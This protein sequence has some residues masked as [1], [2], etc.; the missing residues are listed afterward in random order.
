MPLAT[1]NFKSGNKHLHSALSPCIECSC[2]TSLIILKS[3][4]ASTSS[5]KVLRRYQHKQPQHSCS[6]TC[7]GYNNSM[8]MCIDS[9]FS[10][11]TGNT[12][13]NG[14][15][16]RHK[17]KLLQCYNR[18]SGAHLRWEQASKRHMLACCVVLE[19]HRW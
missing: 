18:V 9:K 19:L 16:Y 4:I 7:Q 3:R 10:V 2:R 12:Q 6:D 13:M 11:T 5:A 1:H 8:K 17:H 14:R 15:R